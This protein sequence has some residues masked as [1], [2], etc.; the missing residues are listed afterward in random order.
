VSSILGLGH[1]RLPGFQFGVI[2]NW[3]N[4][5]GRAFVDG[6]GRPF[7]EQ[8]IAEGR[9]HVVSQTGD[10]AAQLYAVNTPRQGLCNT[11]AHSRPVYRGK[12]VIWQISGPKRTMAD[13]KVRLYVC[14]CHDSAEIAALQETCCNWNLRT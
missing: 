10:E 6:Y 9:P 4:K 13:L 11:N 8:I 12:A 14:G 5:G 7:G 3:Q 1:C 2:L